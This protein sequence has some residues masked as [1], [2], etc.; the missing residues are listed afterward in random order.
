MSGEGPDGKTRPCSSRCPSSLLR[1]RH[2]TVGCTAEGAC[3]STQKERR[4]SLRPWGTFPGEEPRKRRVFLV[5][6]TPTASCGPFIPLRGAWKQERA[7]H[8]KG[9]QRAWMDALVPRFSSSTTRGNEPW[10]RHMAQPLAY[11]GE[12]EEAVGLEPLAECHHL[13][14]KELFSSC[15]TPSPTARQL[16]LP[17]SNSISSAK[18]RAGTQ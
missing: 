7:W 15:P 10:P 13:L 6:K 2:D 3:N 4:K 9:K 14:Y 18:I 8:R 17:L 5:P 11:R 1:R 16:S 12:A